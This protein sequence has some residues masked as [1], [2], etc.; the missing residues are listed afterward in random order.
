MIQCWNQH[1]CDFSQ[2]SCKRHD[3]QNFNR[4][5]LQEISILERVLA[6]VF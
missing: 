2:Q 3:R 5:K 4:R 6:E 1:E